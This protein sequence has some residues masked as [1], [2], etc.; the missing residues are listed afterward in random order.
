M[1]IFAL[2]GIRVLNLAEIQSTL[3]HNSK[4]PPVQFVKKK[5]VGNS[6]QKLLRFVMKNIIW[7]SR[8]QSCIFC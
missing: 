1:S 3:S 6:T 4:M 5:I 7:G 8:E 2:S